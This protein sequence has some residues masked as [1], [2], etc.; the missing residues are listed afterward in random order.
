[1]SRDRVRV[2][3]GRPDGATGFWSE[4]ISED[5]EVIDLG[6][7]NWS[8]VV[9]FPGEMAGSRGRQ[10]AR[11]RGLLVIYRG[12]SLVL[13]IDLSTSEP[14]QVDWQGP[15]GLEALAE[16]SGYRSIL[17]FE[18]A[19][20]HKAFGKARTAI[21]Y[22]EEL[23]K[24]WDSLLEILA[25]GWGV[26]VFTYPAGPEE[27]PLGK[28]ESLHGKLDMLVPDNSLVLI[29]AIEHGKVWASV[30][31]GYRARQVW[32]LTS[33]ETIGLQDADLKEHDLDEMAGLLEEKFDGTFRAITFD[34]AH[35]EKI[36]ASRFP[37][38]EMTM[39]MSN[40]TI[41]MHNAP[42]RWK[43]MLITSGAVTSMTKEK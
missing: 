16:S 30:I 31:I 21:D 20:L 37:A 12:A 22:T 40:G 41:R 1:M 19:V 3:I 9:R 29:A 5:I 25:R 32:L 4:M 34:R 8:R 28:K 36:M 39:G 24:E 26:S 38:M 35:M 10:D 14:V 15:D 43:A 13:A 6:K 11:W 2:I 23:L 33:L 18:Q 17:A 7:L 42:K 27:F